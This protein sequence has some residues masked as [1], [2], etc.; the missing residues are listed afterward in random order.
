MFMAEEDAYK[1]TIAQL[2]QDLAESIAAN[3]IS[4]ENL[5]K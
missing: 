5:E 3:I 2:E 1:N 4:V